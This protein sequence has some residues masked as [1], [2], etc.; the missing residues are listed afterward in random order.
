MNERRS[1][2]LALL[3]SE[4]SMAITDLSTA[5]GV[6][7]ETVRKDLYQLEKDGL[8]TKVRGGAVLTASN[9]ETAY[10]L[11][12]GTRRDAKQA[13][14]QEAVRLV[15]PGDTVYL[16]YGTT[17]FMIASQLLPLEDITVVT[18]ALPT[19]ERL[20][21]KPSISVLVPGGMLRGSENSLY[22]PLTARNLRQLHFDI[23][24]FGCVGVDPEIG[25]TNPNQFESEISSL[26]MERCSTVVM[27]VDHSKFGVIAA[28]VTAPT[29]GPDRLITDAQAPEPVLADLRRAGLAVRI[30][31]AE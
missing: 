11:R 21:G 1:Q 14:A 8:L 6:S 23:G 13:I 26:A 22:G 4:E 28:N 24:F 16:D 2:I 10:E 20:A 29:T 12:L 15:S 9:V 17:A 27:V 18:N 19:A 30:A 7:R 31:G 5:L 25:F 3:K